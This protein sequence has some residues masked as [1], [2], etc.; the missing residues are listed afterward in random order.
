MAL[1]TLR[2]AADALGV[3]LDDAQLDQ[4]ERFRALLI[5]WNARVNLTAIAE[6]D[7]IETLHFVDSLA[8]I[9]ALGPLRDRTVHLIDVGTGAGL[10][11]LALR[12]ALPDTT[13]TLAD[14]VGKKTAFL[15][16]AIHA[17]QLDGVEIVTERAEVLGQ[18]PAHRE[19][20]DV[21]LARAVAAMP[22]LVELCLPLVRV[23]GRFLAHKK[24]DIDD[25]IH[26]ADRAITLLGGRLATPYLPD[27]PG[28][29]TDRQ[30]VVVEKDRPTPQPYPRRV[31]LPNKVPL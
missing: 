10:P 22:T 13:L 19:R 4:L 1:E 25:E 15:E 5:E 18:Q 11:G 16:A 28:L 27:L 2:A 24:R 20:Y 23:G 6:P 21:A 29:S 3:A 17:L 31:G 26:R 12:I 14:S 8:A 7:A 30:I 9:G